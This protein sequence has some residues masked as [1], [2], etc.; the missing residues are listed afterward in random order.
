MHVGA[1]A[2]L[3]AFTKNYARLVDVLPV[4][5]LTHH[6]IKDN[7]ISLD[8]LKIILQTPSRSE[9]AG[10]VLR[11]IGGSLKANLTTSFDKLLSIMEQHGSISCLE[12]AS[13]IRQDL[14]KETTRKLYIIFAMYIIHVS[15]V[16]YVIKL[17][18]F[19]ALYNETCMTS[20]LI[21][22]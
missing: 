18:A 11:K 16:Q 17:P 9:A 6:F 22:L 1:K 7:V 2:K 8:E 5:S 14:L 21:A 15:C 12:L 13:D 3:A 19:S 4:K 20:L 10:M